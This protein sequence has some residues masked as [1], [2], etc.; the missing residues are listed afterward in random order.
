MC[1]RFV[2]LIEN[3]GS[4]GYVSVCNLQVLLQSSLFQTIQWYFLRTTEQGYFPA[5]TVVHYQSIPP[6][7][8]QGFPSIC[9]DTHWFEMVLSQSCLLVLT[10]FT[11]RINYP[12]HEFQIAFDQF[13]QT[14]FAQSPFTETHKK[15][16]NDC[17]D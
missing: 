8:C 11:L 17:P 3:K 15:L 1:K 7:E 4:G 12:T 16:H 13:Y 14:F 5:L 2:M 10:S 6:S 9:K